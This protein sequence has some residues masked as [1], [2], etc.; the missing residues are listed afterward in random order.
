MARVARGT[1]SDAAG[2]ADLGAR[3]GAA[4]TA[5][6]AAPKQTKVATTITKPKPGKLQIKNPDCRGHAV[7]DAESGKKFANFHDM[8]FMD[9]PA[10]TYSVAFGPTV[11]RGAVVGN[12]S[13]FTSRM[14]VP[15][16]STRSRSKARRPR[17][18]FRKARPWRSM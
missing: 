1:Y 6:P 7:T 8:T 13:S 17:S 14:P 9:L 3:L 11:W 18:T 15:P 16:G 12:V 2:A 4:A 5:K 10:G